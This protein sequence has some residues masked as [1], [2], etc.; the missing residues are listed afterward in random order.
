MNNIH[1]IVI[2][3]GGPA[4]L[5]AGLY[6]ARARMN[7]LLVE[8]AMP[9]G[10]ILIADRVENFPGF[11]EGVSGPELAGFMEKQAL[12]FGL[13]IKTCDASEIIL[14]S[15][16]KLFR[17]KFS[18]GN[19]LETLSVIVATGANWN[20]LGIPGE[21]ELAGRG[22]SYCATCDG[23][24]FKGKDVVVVGGGDTALEDGLFLAKFAKKVTIVHRRD[25]F[26]AAKILQERAAA[27]KNIGFCMNSIALEIIGK[28][29]VEGLKV[30]DVNS[31]AT[32]EIKSDG[33]FIFVGVTPNSEIAKAL[34]KADEKGYIITD[35]GMETSVEGIFACG[36]VRKKLLRQVVTATGEGASAA[37][38]AQ[39]YV[40]RLKGVEY[41]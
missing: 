25:R 13:K 30:K 10:Q 32:K 28:N 6:A 34:V 3:G 7:V 26:R 29:K 37:V 12:N 18:D 22:V 36:D 11:P 5:T 40:E 19:I 15:S 21:K 27:N 17:I 33:I 1:D 14:D 38:N 35:D 41:K 31:A 16:P 2:I 8:K 24:L 20:Q 4:G 9:G 23:P 39:N